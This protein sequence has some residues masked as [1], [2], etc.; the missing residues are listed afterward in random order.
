MANVDYPTGYICGNRDGR[1]NDSLYRDFK[2]RGKRIRLQ[3]T[4][5][6]RYAIS[7]EL[8]GWRDS[9]PYARY[10]G[11]GGLRLTLARIIYLFDAQKAIIAFIYRIHTVGP[12]KKI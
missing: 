10:T 1:T 12:S 2:S 11:G 6:P 5:V 7:V 9:T 8:W 3:L 4:R